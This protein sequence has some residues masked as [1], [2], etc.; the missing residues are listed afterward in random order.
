MTRWS[1]QDLAERI[2]ANPGLRLHRQNSAI[3]APLPRE[4]PRQA[5]SL[6]GGSGRPEPQIS[7]NGDTK[8]PRRDYKSELLQQLA[9]LGISPPES[10]FRFCERKWRFDWAYP[11]KLLAIEYQG[12]AYYKGMGHQTTAG[13]TKDCL[14]FSTAASLGW[15]IIL[16]TAGMVRDG[17]AAQLIEKALKGTANVRSER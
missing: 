10:E 11:E 6:S 12:G 15:R 9:I 4:K 13:F 5:K 17:S 7:L 14:K 8:K 1:P 2:A 3:P 16:V